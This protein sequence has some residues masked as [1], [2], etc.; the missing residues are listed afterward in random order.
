MQHPYQ[1]NG[2]NSPIFSSISIPV[3][4]NETILIWTTDKAANTTACLNTTCKYN[5]TLALA[6]SF[7]FSGLSNGTI[8][9]FSLLSSVW[10]ERGGNDTY[11]AS[12]LR[13]NTSDDFANMSVGIRPGE[14]SP[15]NTL[16]LIVAITLLCGLLLLFSLTLDAK[17]HMFLKIILSLAFVYLILFIPKAAMDMDKTCDTVIDSVTTVG[18]SNYYNYQYVCIDN[19]Y[20]TSYSFFKAVSLLQKVIT[21]YIFIYIIWYFWLGKKLVQ[22]GIIK[23]KPK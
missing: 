9:N 23:E 18:S 5:A 17:E 14:G 3:N 15:K 20:T 8:Y 13:T 7:L 1:Y 6:H 4:N 16:P 2:N 11:Y 22:I 12:T 21:Y 19:I 10:T